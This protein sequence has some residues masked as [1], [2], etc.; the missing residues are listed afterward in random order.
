[1]KL[2]IKNVDPGLAHLLRSIA[3]AGGGQVEVAQD[4]EQAS[5][6]P[7]AKPATKRSR[8]DGTQQG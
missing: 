8:R 4:E 7:V 3:E 5:E 2:T 6:K 1:M